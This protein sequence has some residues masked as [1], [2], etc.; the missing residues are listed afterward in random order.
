MKEIILNNIRIQ[1][2][3]KNIKTLRLSVHPPDGE[4]RLSVPH[5]ISDQ[6]VKEFIDSR[7]EWIIR[8]IRKVN[9]TPRE[10][11]K[12]YISGEN[13]MFLGT[14]YR[15]SLQETSGKQGA[16]IEDGELVLFVKDGHTKE[17]REK[18]LKEW[19]R[20]QLKIVIP[21]FIAK[22]EPILK[23]EVKDWGVKDMKTRWGTCN[24]RDKRIWINLQLAKKDERYLE[25]IIVHEMNHLLERLHNDKFKE[26]MTKFLPGWEELKRGL[27]Y[28]E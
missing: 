15:L 27:N 25:Y 20:E 10:T 6:A 13:H 3:R 21:G 22:W 1:L 8:Q 26:H 2:T 28:K 16:E 19:Y 18:L 9:S 7:E 14:E 17:N 23:V 5:R 12:E 24:T 4:V 11:A